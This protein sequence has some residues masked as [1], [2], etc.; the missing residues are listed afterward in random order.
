MTERETLLCRSC[1]GPTGRQSVVCQYCGASFAGAPGRSQMVYALLPD[2]P[3]GRAAAEFLATIHNQYPSR[4]VI[5]YFRT[6]PALLQIAEDPD[7]LESVRQA[8]LEA[9]VTR[10]LSVPLIVREW[11]DRIPYENPTV[12]AMLADQLDPEKIRNRLQAP[13]PRKRVAYLLAAAVLLV[14]LSALV[15][16]CLQNEQARQAEIERTRM[17]RLLHPQPAAWLD[18]LHPLLLENAP[19]WGL[20]GRPW[21]LDPHPE[22][23]IENAE[24]LEKLS[25]RFLYTGPLR[26]NEIF[27]GNDLLQ[28]GRRVFHQPFSAVGGRSGKNPARRRNPVA[29]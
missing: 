28:D 11:L 12:N 27:P 1:G 5:E 19:G 13:S 6:P 18:A 14:F 7:R 9:A 10:G 26:C 23:R 21:R 16:W 2:G 29:G 4:T 3:P 22:I 20:P 15:P 8:I 17:L 24:P 25:L